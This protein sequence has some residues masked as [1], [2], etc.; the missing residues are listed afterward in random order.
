MYMLVAGLGSIVHVP[1]P[2]KIVG[3]TH[4]QIRTHESR[5]LPYPLWIFFC[6]YSSDLEKKS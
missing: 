6:G 4:T 3:N 2:F 5:V 1:I